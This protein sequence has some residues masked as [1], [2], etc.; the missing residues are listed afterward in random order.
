MIL[1]FMAAA[2]LSVTTA[3]GQEAGVGAGRIEIG[4]FPVGGMAFGHDEQT[5][6]RTSAT[7]RWVRRSQSTSTNGSGS[8]E[9]LAAVSAFV[10]I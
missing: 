8:K 1:A 4:G 7:T 9:R 5:D 3:Y 10:T 2:A 6:G